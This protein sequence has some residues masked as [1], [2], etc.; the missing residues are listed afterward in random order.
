MS[1][2]APPPQPPRQPEPPQ[3]PV[4]PGPLPPPEAGVAFQ[5]VDR[6]YAYARLLT[7]AIFLVGA[8]IVVLVVGIL[9]W[10]PLMWIGLPV[11]AAWAIFAVWLIFRQTK[12]FGYAER[13]SDL[14]V[15]HGIMFHTTSVVPYGRLQYVEVSSG[16]IERMFGLAGVELHTASAS[17]DA[18]IPGLPRAE[19]E[20][21]RDELATRGESQLAGL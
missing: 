15:R 16:P 14:L 11:I 3:R 4:Q 13:A 1:I 17:T 8:L 12:A 20:R 7:E 6:K 19:A 5:P 9:F 18:T 10:K 2:P 21:L